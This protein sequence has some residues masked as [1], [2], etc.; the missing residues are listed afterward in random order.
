MSL[1][2]FSC[3]QPQYVVE[4]PPSAIDPKS[5]V[6]NLPSGDQLDRCED[7]EN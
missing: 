4:K 5:G 6:N 2:E 1:L 3:D 7:P